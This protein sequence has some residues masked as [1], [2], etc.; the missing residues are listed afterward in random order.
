MS[1]AESALVLIPRF[2][3]FVGE[4]ERTSVPIDVSSY[5]SAQ[6]ELWRG[7][8]F[9]SGD[10]TPAKFRAYLEESLDGVTWQPPA[11]VAHGY[12][13]GAEKSAV[14]SHMFT[15]RWFRIRVKVDIGS[16]F[17][18]TTPMVSCWAEGMLR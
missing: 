18:P 14:L 2:T 3:S 17:P 5:S 16:G 6:I 1:G 7:P 13:P 15:M 4:G 12:D 8:L 10:D 9:G 11:D